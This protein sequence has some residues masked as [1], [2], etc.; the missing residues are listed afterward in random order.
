ML[1]RKKAISRTDVELAA[2]LEQ[3]S[4]SSAPTPVVEASA[5]AKPSEAKT[6]EDQRDLIREHCLGLVGKLKRAKR[7]EWNLR[8]KLLET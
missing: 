6:R 4:L 3:F 8:F 1:I 2:S 5:S 7:R